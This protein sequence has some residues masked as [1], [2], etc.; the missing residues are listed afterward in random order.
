[1]TSLIIFRPSVTYSLYGPFHTDHYGIYILLD[2]NSQPTSVTKTL[3]AISCRFTK[4]FPSPFPWLAQNSVP[5]ARASQTPT[6][7]NWRVQPLPQPRF[8]F[9]LSRSV[10]VLTH[11]LIATL[12]SQAY[13]PYCVQILGYKLLGSWPGQ[14]PYMINGNL[15][16][17]TVLNLSD[18]NALRLKASDPAVS[19]PFPFHPHLPR[20]FHLLMTRTS[21]ALLLLVH[22]LWRYPRPDPGATPG[23]ILKPSSP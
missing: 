12:S 22:P 14:T 17:Y 5:T 8:F 11:F 6:R 4:P 2:T 10:L 9:T 16:A 13:S 20:V 18:C 3:K 15:G 1:M 19:H 21:S 7:R 23:L